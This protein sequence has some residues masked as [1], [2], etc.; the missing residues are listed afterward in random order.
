MTLRTVQQISLAS[1]F[2]VNRDSPFRL[3]E[4]LIQAGYLTQEQFDQCCR[5]SAGATVAQLGQ[6]LIMSGHLTHEQLNSALDAQA[7]LKDRQIDQPLAVKALKVS[8]AHK[9]SFKQSIEEL[10]LA[11]AIKDRSSNR[12]GELLIAADIIT[13]E[14]CQ[15]ALE[16]NLS[17]GLPLGRILVISRIISESIL[18]VALNAQIMIRDGKLTRQQG[19]YAL[20]AVHSRQVALEESLKEFGIA[21]ADMP[22]FKLGELLVGAGLVNQ[23]ELIDSV[24]VGLMAGMPIGEVLLNRGLISRQFL[25]AAIEFQQF[26]LDGALRPDQAIEVLRAMRVDGVQTLPTLPAS[27]TALLRNAEREAIPEHAPKPNNKNVDQFNKA[28]ALQVLSKFSQSAGSVPFSSLRTQCVYHYT[29]SEAPTRVVDNVITYEQ[30]LVL[31]R[32]ATPDK[33][34]SAKTMCGGTDISLQK[35]LSIL[36]VAPALVVSIADFAFQLLAEGKLSFEKCIFTVEYVH[37]AVRIAGLND[38]EAILNK[39]GEDFGIW[40]PLWF[41]R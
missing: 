2:K 41:Y 18:V 21:N 9:I 19:A 37:E 38:A 6:V 28:E 15:R 35:A 5:I 32:V 31:T 20:R 22:H 30:F 39:L 40:Q 26:V 36:R 13:N 29:P 1:S 17:T 10:K 8:R 34:D 11:D 23:S 7:C 25:D 27:S 3:G 4:L 14:Q 12:V 33:L 24:E 16:K